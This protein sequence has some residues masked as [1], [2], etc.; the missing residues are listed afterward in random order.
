LE[1]GVAT[2]RSINHIA[3]LQPKRPIHGFDSFEG[4]PETWT[5]RF[6]RGHFAQPTPTVK[7][8]INLHVGWFNDTLPKFL[9]TNIK[10]KTPI[11]LLHIDGDLYSSAKTFLDFLQKHIVPGTIIMFDEYMNYPGWQHHEFKAWQENCKE[12]TREYEYIGYVSSHQQ[13]VVRVKK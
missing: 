13:V 2:G 5:S 8:N 7:D 9:T 6:D 12:F 11:A 1:F 10:V 4:L 3:R